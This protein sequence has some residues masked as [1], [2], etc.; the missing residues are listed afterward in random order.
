MNVR[1][2]AVVTERAY[3]NYLVGWLTALYTFNFM[4]LVAFFMAMESIKRSLHLSDAALGLVGGLAYS[5]F[6]SIFGIGLGRWADTGNRVSV[7]AV[8]R[9][10][11]AVFVLLTARAQ[12][13]WQLFTVRMGVAAGESGCIPPAYSLIGEHFP[14]AERPRA[15]GILFLGIP[16]AMVLGYFGAGWLIQRE[17]W[18]AMFMIMGLPGFAFAAITWATLKEPRKASG[19]ALARAK[20]QA[21]V[22][23]LWQ[24]TKRLH[25]IATYR[26]MLLAL[27][28]SLFFSTGLQQWESAFFMRT[29]GM[30]AD[31]LGEWL[32][33]A[34][35]IPGVV[36]SLL[37]GVVASRW[38]GGNERA[39]LLAVTVL[40]CSVSFIFPFVFLTHDAVVA[41]ALTGVFS[42][43]SAMMSA[44]M[45]AP[46][47]AAV[48][49]RIHA[50]SFV[51]LY[52]FGSLI[53]SGLGPLV[54]GA[55]S[56]ALRDRFGN[57]SL[58]YAL[59]LMSPWFFLCGWLTWRASKTV[60]AD[61]AAVKEEEGEM[62]WPE[63]KMV[64]PT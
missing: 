62:A 56:D 41:F 57:D 20:S 19:F 5:S 39:Q 22:Q 63:A 43:V 55:L 54:T 25:S 48:P 29:Y 44:P 33:I 3:R 2:G 32:A 38:A 34:Y 26:Y 45:I 60:N 46:L 17:G 1:Q 7:L 40:F 24:T 11:W 16:L 15:L 10:V 37:G 27:A 13:F 59:A 9:I 6:Y 12:S 8:T 52:L 53:G 51:I 18:R 35:G 14:R 58:R 36:G 31:V 21:D 49:P 28:V 42:F 4:D 47:Q 50:L 64:G 30:R 61:I 23:P